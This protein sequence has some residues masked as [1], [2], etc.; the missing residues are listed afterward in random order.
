MKPAE[1]T[2]QNSSQPFNFG[3][4][5]VTKYFET[6]RIS[7]GLA[8]LPAGGRGDIDPGHSDAEEVIY[9]T[10]GAVVC[11]FPDN[12]E[13]VELS[14]GEAVLIPEDRPHQL[15]NRSSQS[16]SITYSCAPRL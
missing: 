6:D 4:L 10:E 7:F 11:I 15:E 3:D 16:A 2:G 12:G 9:V 5:V 1:K 13:E 8:T 14:Q